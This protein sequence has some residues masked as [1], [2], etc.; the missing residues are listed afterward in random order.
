MRI[1]VFGGTFDP[2]HKGHE[3]FLKV[4]AEACQ[5]HAVLVVPTG[6]PPHKAANGTPAHLRVEMCKAAFSDCAEDVQVSEL[7]IQREGRSFTVDTIA[8]IK[9]QKPD[10]EIFLAVGGDMLL[11]FKQWN[12]YSEILSACTL[13]ALAREDGSEEALQ[14]AAHDLESRGGRV[15]LAAGEV[16][17]LSSSEI[18]AAHTRGEDISGLVSEGVLEIIT[19]NNLYKS[20]E[21]Y[22]ADYR[23]RM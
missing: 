20:G 3:N 22:R 15:V 13:V 7:E 8:F 18:R 1:L 11:S 16:M 17:Q 19:A 21:R 6:T 4:C 9:N 12:R 14:K 10:A 5:P 2:P 23:D